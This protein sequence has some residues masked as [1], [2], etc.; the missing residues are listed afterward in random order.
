MSTF[1]QLCASLAQESGAVGSAPSSVTGQSGRQA[2]CVSWVAEAWTQMQ[3]ELSNANFLS[4]EFEGSLAA[5]TLT[6]AASDLGI[7]DFARWLGNVSIYPPADQASEKDLIFMDH[8][9]WRRT[10]NFGS[11]DA[12]EPV[13]WSIAPDESLCVGPKPDDTYTIRGQ[14]QRSPQ[15]LA[16]NADVPILPERFHMAIVHRANMLLCA[17]DEAWDALKGAERKYNPYLLDISRDCLPSV[18]TTGNRLA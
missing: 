6:Y 11:H 2:K 8:G 16:A 10:Y 15:V 5:D 7:S 14:Y 9:T 18:T 1:L 3:N 12:N 13:Y 17:A 4:K